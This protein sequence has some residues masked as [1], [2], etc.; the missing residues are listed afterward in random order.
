MGLKGKRASSFMMLNDI[1]NLIRL[2]QPVSFIN[3]FAVVIKPHQVCHLHSMRKS[4]IDN[5]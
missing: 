1:P 4:S 3:L 5:F 2:N